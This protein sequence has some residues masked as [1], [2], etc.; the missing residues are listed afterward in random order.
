[1]AIKV[2]EAPRIDPRVVRTRKLL[3]DALDGLLKER[4]FDTIGIQDITDR[5]TVNRA[6]FYAHYQDKYALLDAIVRENFALRLSQGN[7]LALG[8]IRLVLKA[9]ATNTFAFIGEHTACG[10]DRAFES[11]LQRA[12]ELELADFLEPM[13]RSCA[14]MLVGS[15]IVGAAVQWRAQKGTISSRRVVDEIATLLADG[16]R[17]AV[18]NGSRKA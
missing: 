3:R 16:V 15:A 13:L 5:A 14:S 1:M 18:V 17:P 12:M 9:V 10:V 4:S 7:P 2:P 11:Q 8:D 6:T